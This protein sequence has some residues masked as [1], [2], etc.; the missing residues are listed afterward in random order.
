MNKNLS[1]LRQL[2]NEIRFTS[3]KKTI[4]DNLVMQYVIEQSRAHK[5]TTEV[6][7]KARE[8]MQNL[9]QNYACYLNSLRKYQEINSFYSGKGERSIKE[10]ANLVGFKLP[11]DP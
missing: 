2:A 6:L 1:I 5:P 8:E 9:A 4:K 7:C 3:S 10:T 11:H